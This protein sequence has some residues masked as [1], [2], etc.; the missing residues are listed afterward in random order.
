MF[1]VV[2]DIFPNDSVVVNDEAFVVF[3][4]LRTPDGRITLLLD[5]VSEDRGIRVSFAPL[6]LVQV[7]DDED[8]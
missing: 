4:T 7:I 6:D 8:N 3:D 2:Q 5:S 1:S